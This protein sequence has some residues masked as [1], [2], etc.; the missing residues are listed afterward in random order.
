M[1]SK[2][3]KGSYT[4][5]LICSMVLVF[6]FQNYLASSIMPNFLMNFYLISGGDDNPG[7]YTGQFYRLLTSVFLHG[8]LMHIGF[9]MLAYYYLGNIVEGYFTKY[10]Y[11]LI[12]II[13]STGAS[14]VSILT[15]P[16]NTP[17]I[18]ASGMIYGLFGVILIYAKEIGVEIKNFVGVI[19]INLSLSFVMPGI[20]WHA[21]LGGLVVG[22]MLG[23]IMKK[24]A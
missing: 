14:L 12:L 23:S 21:H 20:D 9:N 1:I 4:N 5:K 22:V 3:F 16:T 8:N 6:L 24:N 18:G 17:A 11:F 7:V 13:V 19:V 15:N 10:R 2:F